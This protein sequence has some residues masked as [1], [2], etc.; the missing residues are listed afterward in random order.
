MQ[1]GQGFRGVTHGMVM[2]EYKS[3]SELLSWCRPGN[4]KLVSCFLVTSRNVELVEQ[5]VM[6][7]YGILVS[8]SYVIRS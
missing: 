4:L 5:V 7:E 2:V 6:D 1:L 3:R 8:F